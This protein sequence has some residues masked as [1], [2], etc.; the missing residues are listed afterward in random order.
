MDSFG[1]LL[2]EPPRDDVDVGRG[3]LKGHSGFEP[4]LK[5]EVS[6]ADVRIHTIECHRPPEIGRKLRE[7]RRHDAHERGRDA[8]EDERTAED[9]GIQVVRTRSG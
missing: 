5:R 9:A 8:V 3:L 7:P 6:P 4:G 2:R 1:I